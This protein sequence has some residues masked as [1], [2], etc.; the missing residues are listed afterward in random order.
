[1]KNRRKSSRITHNG[2]GF[3]DCFWVTTTVRP[4]WSGRLKLLF[5][6]KIDIGHDIYSPRVFP[7]EGMV[8]E[9]RFEPEYYW[10]KPI[11]RLKKWWR[12]VWNIR[13]K[14]GEEAPAQM[15]VVDKEESSIK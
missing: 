7:E 15:S 4:D 1:M 11:D 3:A 12:K 6:K 5:A 9:A 13:E 2:Q 14:G 8:T 10:T